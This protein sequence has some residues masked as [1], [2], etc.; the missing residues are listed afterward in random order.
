[1]KIVLWKLSVLV[2][3]AL[4]CSAARRITTDTDEAILSPS[5]STCL[6]VADDGDATA[7]LEDSVTHPTANITT[8]KTNTKNTITDGTVW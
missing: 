1:M 7:C 6:S 4:P 3:V 8:S 5:T 2:A